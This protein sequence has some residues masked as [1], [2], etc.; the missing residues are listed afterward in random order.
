[1]Y[2]IESIRR[3]DDSKEAVVICNGEYFRIT[4]HDLDM[5]QIEELSEIDEEGRELLHQ[6]VVRLSCIKKAF[7]H[8]SYGDLTEKQLRDKLTRKFDRELAADVASL[9]VERGYVNDLRIA[10]R[11][12]ETFY[13]FKNMGLN[14]IRSELYRRGVSKENIKVV[15][16]KYEDEDQIERVEEFVRKKYD[17]SR[18]D[19]MNYRRKVYASAVRAGFSNSDI[20]DFLRNFESEY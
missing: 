8:L 20:S 18:L 7:D 9:F 15:M 10:E 13:D 11:Y 6:A 12:A 1:M 14:R 2:K 4:V 5:L 17:V 16:S 3:N 19:D